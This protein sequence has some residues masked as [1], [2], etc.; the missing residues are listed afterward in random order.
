MIMGRYAQGMF[1]FG[2]ILQDE[3]VTHGIV[4]S[5]V[6]SFNMLVPSLF[7]MYSFYLVGD[8]IPLPYFISVQWFIGVCAQVKSQF[9]TICNVI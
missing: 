6:F 4:V 7:I 1:C 3:L 9:L 8:R 2:S 5:R